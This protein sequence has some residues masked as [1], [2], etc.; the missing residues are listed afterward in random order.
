MGRPSAAPVTV[1]LTAR[2]F[3]PPPRRPAPGFLLFSFVFFDGTP[4]A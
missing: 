1:W 3:L 4:L 2:Q